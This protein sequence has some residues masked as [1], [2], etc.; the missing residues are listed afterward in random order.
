MPPK[1][2]KRSRV[3][4][5]PTIGAA[6]K[7]WS[8]WEALG[9]P[10]PPE[11]QESKVDPYST[12]SRYRG[13]EGPVLPRVETLARGVM[14]LTGAS[15]LDIRP[16]QPYV[17]GQEFG[18]MGLPGGPVKPKVRPGQLD[19]LAGAA[20]DVVDEA[21]RVIAPKQT[22]IAPRPP[23]PW[24]QNV[25]ATP[26]VKPDE[27]R[28]RPTYREPR[29]PPSTPPKP[30]VG[31]PATPQTGGIPLAKVLAMDE[32]E[33]A[34]LVAERQA[35]RRGVGTPRRALLGN[36]VKL[37]SGEIATVRGISE[38]TGMIRVT[39][40]SIP[41]PAGIKDVP[42][43]QYEQIFRPE[44][45]G[46]V[47]TPPGPGAPKVGTPPPTATAPVVKRS[48][49]FADDGIYDVTMPDGTKHQIYRDPGHQFGYPVWYVVGHE[50]DPG[51]L[52][53][54]KAEILN[55]LTKNGQK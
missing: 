40:D 29:Y 51:W 48:A 35:A 27:A 26:K 10:A 13:L 52:G 24:E 22:E 53:Y 32:D 41:G 45:A 38:D 25:P 21:G 16:G 19:L 44:L 8:L 15:N 2:P 23:G 11:P 9:L 34:K 18:A 37:A 4:T 31:Q 42:T 28:V 30:A 39:V 12:L 36:K 50:N 5:P 7:R 33:L 14:D 6:P 3:G 43:G 47:G 55:T 49:T 1:D 54:T 46:R 17:P 20:D